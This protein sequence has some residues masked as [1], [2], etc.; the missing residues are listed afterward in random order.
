[1]KKAKVLFLVFALI[2]V[3]MAVGC[4]NNKEPEQK[5]SAEQTEDS[6]VA[7]PDEMSRQ[8]EV[9][10]EDMRPVEGSSLKDGTYP[11]TV[12]SSS[13]MFHVTECALTVRNGK[14]TAVMTM[15]GTGYLKV[16]MGTGTQAV[17]ASENAYIPFAETSDGKHTFE[18]PVEAL[19]KKISC[20]AFSKNKEKWYDR[21]LVFRADS[22]PQ[23]AFS[24]GA[25]ATAESLK[26]EDGKYTVAVKLEGGSGKAEVQSPAEMRVKD[27]KAYVTLIWSSS[28]YD[29]MKLEGRKYEPLSIEEHS[30]FEIPVGGFDWKMPVKAD[31]IAMSE[32]HEIDY[33]LYFDSA[34]IKKAE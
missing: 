29:Y 3:Q 18:V 34:S 11:V 7:A 24:D 21:T 30:V 20:A 8:M 26:L 1:M 19:D 23:T 9:G 5:T 15:S 2:F 25:I 13:A 10:T 27:K 16:F 31:T 22:I 4:A 12:D 32:P 28:N 6:Q 14:M 33:T 17:Q